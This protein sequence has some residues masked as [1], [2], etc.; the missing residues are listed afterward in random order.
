M[1]QCV[2]AN[3]DAD[4]APNKP[5][6]QKY[7]VQSFPTI[8]FFSK[9][10]KEE[11]EDY[12]GGRTE[13]DFVTFL[14]EKCGTNRAVGGGLDDNVRFWSRLQV[15][16]LHTCLQAGRLAEFDSLAN[17]FLDASGKARDSI[18]KEA[19]TLAKAADA[20]S[21]HYIRV[22][23]KLVNGTENYIEKESKR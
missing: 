23:E 19:L 16:G 22:M 5:L 1:L 15:D 7:G 4:A 10:N 13:A 17:K 21:K 18:Y 12:T 6:A 11:P 14:N 2:V 20:T 3:F 8:K 9:D